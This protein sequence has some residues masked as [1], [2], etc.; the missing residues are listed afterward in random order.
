MTFGSPPHRIEI[1]LDSLAKAFNVRAQFEHIYGYITCFF[2]DPETNQSEILTIMSESNLSLRCIDELYGIYR[3]VLQDKTGADEG[4]RQI[5]VLLA[6]PLSYK[7][8]VGFI[9]SYLA[10][11]I[12]CGV[13]FGGS[14]ND[15]WV[16]GL[17]GF[18]VRLLCR[19]RQFVGAMLV[20][21]VA[22]GLA[23]YH[24]GVFC[25]SA[26]SS[27]GVVSLLPGF[28]LCTYWV[29]NTLVYFE[30]PFIESFGLFRNRCRKSR[31]GGSKIL[32]WI[33]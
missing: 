25:F 30:Y 15:M 1:Q 11:F 8:Y 32:L 3:S 24:G 18:V 2:A 4:A 7:P 28:L 23:T 14:L 13:S 33:I 12:I 17:L 5:R 9:L 27:A 16:A 22:R 31:F 6:N 21:F 20:S 10:S 29:I 26:I 19:G